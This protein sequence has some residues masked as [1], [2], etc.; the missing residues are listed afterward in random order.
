MEERFWN[1]TEKLRN[2]WSKYDQATLRDYLV[3][4]IDGILES[5]QKVLEIFA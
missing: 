1:E 3:K 4:D 2:S 5:F